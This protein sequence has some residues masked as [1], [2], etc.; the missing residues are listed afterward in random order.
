MIS[1]GQILKLKSGFEREYKRRHDELWPEMAVAMSA[2]GVNMIIYLHE[3][4]LF[5]YA[6]APTQEAWDRL[7]NDPVTSRWDQ[8]MG[9]ILESREDGGVFIK[10]LPRMFKFGNLA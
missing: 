2:A 9:D 10:D 3:N 5:L 1:V 6:N 8:Y 7:N 4:L